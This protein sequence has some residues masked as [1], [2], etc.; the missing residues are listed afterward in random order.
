MKC[1]VVSGAAAGIGAA[2]AKHLTDNGYRVVG[3]D[4]HGDVAIQGDVSD[5]ETWRRAVELSDG[6]DALVCNAYTVTVKPLDFTTPAEW[7]RQLA[8]NLSGAF[9]GLRACLPS[10]R[11]R[12]G[13]VVLVSSVHAHFGIPGHG[14]YAATKGGLVALTRQLAVEYA[15][16]VRVNAVLPGPV[17]TAA[18]DRVS[19]ED[20]E[21]S[22]RATPA[23][24]LGDPAEVASV[25][26]FL[27]SPAA[28]FV[29]GAELL[30]D[31]GWSAAKDSS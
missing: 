2:T 3:I 9:H 4:L 31:G 22:A 1:A 16:D 8:V 13:S 11:Q 23:G 27:L 6:V 20:R 29:T 10:L 28:S 18:W 30:V 7:E 24:R 26:G 19:A 17:L 12:Q 5:P 25:I 15:P 14:A 21:R